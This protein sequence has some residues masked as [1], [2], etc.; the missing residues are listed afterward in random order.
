METVKAICKYKNIYLNIY[1]FVFDGCG[2]TGAFIPNNVSVDYGL[3]IFVSILGFEN[4]EGQKFMSPFGVKLFD[5]LSYA[6][7][8]PSV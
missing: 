6:R 2:E 1:I 3:I 4:E 8:N 7:V 5:A